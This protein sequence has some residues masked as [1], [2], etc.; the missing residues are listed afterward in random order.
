M[1]LLTK[2]ILIF[3]IFL[4]QIISNGIIKFDG[5][6][7]ELAFKGDN[8]PSWDFVEVNMQAKS[9]KYSDVSP[10]ESM[11]LT[12]HTFFLVSS[13]A[14]FYKYVSG[15]VFIRI[16]GFQLI[17]AHQIKAALDQNL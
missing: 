9:I 17:D 10:P 1:K 6:D 11:Y 16:A 2:N 4:I 8:N 12:F 7:V 13:E 15:G 14:V 5:S 3:L